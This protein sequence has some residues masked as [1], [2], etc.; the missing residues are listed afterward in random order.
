M[1]QVSLVSTKKE[2]KNTTNPLT[3]ANNRRKSYIKI[4][5]GK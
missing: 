3:E 5:M 2:P 1:A 4:E